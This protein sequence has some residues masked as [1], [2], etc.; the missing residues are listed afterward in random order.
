MD[1]QWDDALFLLRISQEHSLTHHG[2]SDICE[3]MQSYAE[4]LCH[5]VAQK[6]EK[7]LATIDGIGPAI[8]EELIS[9]CEPSDRFA[10]LKSRHL[11][12]KYYE[13]HYNY[14]VSFSFI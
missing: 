1:P 8:T 5:E 2:I 7:K 14:V 9:L 13:R 3:T 6:I 10:S 12:E 11:R 4:M